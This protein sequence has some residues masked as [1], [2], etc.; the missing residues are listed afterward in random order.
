MMQVTADM[1][2]VSFDDGLSAVDVQ[3]P[4]EAGPHDILVVAT[5]GTEG[6]ARVRVQVQGTSVPGCTPHWSLQISVVNPAPAS[7]IPAS[8]SLL[9]L[10]MWL[11]GGNDYPVCTRERNQVTAP[12]GDAESSG[13]AAGRGAR[14][15]G[16]L[17][18]RELE[19]MLL[20]ARGNTSR[21]IGQALFISPRTVEMHVQGSL[22]KLGCRTR[23]QAVR[24]LADLGT[25]P[26]EETTHTL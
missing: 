15:A 10:P 21:Q 6:T 1:V 13:R 17:T 22:L 14:P 11:E 16:G 4:G 23:A 19:I 9:S 12:A 25:L 8:A 20:V 3:A 26:P 24:R 2:T 18:G 5:A 7:S